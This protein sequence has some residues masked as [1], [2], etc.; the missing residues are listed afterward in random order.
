LLCVGRFFL[1]H[2]YCRFCFL[3]FLLLVVVI[4]LCL[5]ACIFVFLIFLFAG[6]RL[7]AFMVI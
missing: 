3:L 6:G 4:G 2:W 1:C 7:V 5:L